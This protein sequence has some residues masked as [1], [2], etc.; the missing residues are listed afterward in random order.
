MV[1]EAAAAAEGIMLAATFEDMAAIEED[2]AIMVALAKLVVAPMV[3]VIMVED[4][5]G[6][7]HPL[8]VVEDREEMLAATFVM[9]VNVTIEVTLAE[10]ENAEVTA[11]DTVDST[12]DLLLEEAEDTTVHLA[13]EVVEEVVMAV[14]LKLP[15]VEDENVVTT[16]RHLPVEENDKLLLL[17]AKPW[18]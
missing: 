7:I 17:P 8:E 4:T 16:V 12:V 1:V 18:L 10:M 14:A 13:V 6:T 15:A 9:A 2:M 3:H 5:V 11:I